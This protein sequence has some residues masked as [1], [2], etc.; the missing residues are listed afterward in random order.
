MALG[1]KQ[2]VLSAIKMVLE[3]LNQVNGCS[4]VRPLEQEAQTFDM[5]N[6]IA[7]L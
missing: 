3:V 2:G 5:P 1:N 7:D 4:T 6:W